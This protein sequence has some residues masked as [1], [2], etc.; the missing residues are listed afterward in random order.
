MSNELNFKYDSGRTILALIKGPDF[1]QRWNGSSLVAYSSIAD[2]TTNAVQTLDFVDGGGGSGT[3]TLTCEGITT[4]SITYSATPATLVSRINTA[5]N[6]AFGTSC[7]VASGSAITAIALTFSGTGYV[8]RPVGA[9]TVNSSLSNVT[10][11]VI[12]TTTG[13]GW[14]TGMI[15]M[16]ESA[17]SSG[18]ASGNYYGS[19]PA[20]IITAG[21]YVIE[22]YLSIDAKP[23][24]IPKGSQTFWWNGTEIIGA[25]ATAGDEMA[26]TSLY[27]AAKTAATQTSMDAAAINAATAA[28]KASNASNIL[29]DLTEPV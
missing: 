11:S 26:L 6:A 2:S 16:T 7:I 18:T 17:S 1:S 12:Q 19:F 24:V 8:G 22:Y 4:A 23:N 25:P 3:F 10:V 13:V 28:T 5:L 27:D 21:E 15:V 9:V 29:D 20:A 14:E